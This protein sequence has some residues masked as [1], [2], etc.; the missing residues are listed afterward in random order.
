[1]AAAAGIEKFRQPQ[2]RRHWR[3][4]RLIVLSAWL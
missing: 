4:M 1:M 2:R 3:N